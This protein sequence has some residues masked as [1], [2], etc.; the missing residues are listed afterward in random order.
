[1]LRNL[2]FFILNNFFSGLIDAGLLIFPETD[3]S[4]FVLPL[5]IAMT[6]LIFN[7]SKSTIKTLEK[8]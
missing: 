4:F 2:D 8:V 1:M 3:G 6:Q 5:D 7:C